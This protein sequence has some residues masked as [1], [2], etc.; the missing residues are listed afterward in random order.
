M[1]TCH[2]VILLATTYSVRRGQCGP[3]RK[4][5]KGL[6]RA[7]SVVEAQAADAAVAIAAVVATGTTGTTAA[8]VATGTTVAAAATASGVV[9]S[10]VASR[11]LDGVLASSTEERL[12]LRCLRPTHPFPYP[13]ETFARP[14]KVTFVFSSLLKRLC[15]AYAPKLVR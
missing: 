4:V 14:T 1:H 10:P 12:R 13:L 9:D 6:L 11:V 7:R 2:K 8:A 3:P 15:L 5:S